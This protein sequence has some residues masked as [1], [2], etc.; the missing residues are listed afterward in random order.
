MTSQNSLIPLST[1]L[2]RSAVFA[3]A[4]GLLIM[5]QPSERSS[6]QGTSVDVP[7][8]TG[9]PP[10]EIPVPPPTRPAIDVKDEFERATVPPVPTFV[11]TPTQATV[12]LQLPEVTPADVLPNPTATPAAELQPQVDPAAVAAPGTEPQPMNLVA[13]VEVRPMPQINTSSDAHFVNEAGE[14]WVVQIAPGPSRRRDLVINGM[15]YQEVYESIP[16][17]Q[18]E[19]LANPS[20]RHDS[21]MEVLFG[22]LRPTT[23]VRNDSPERIRNTVPAITSPY[24]STPSDVYAYPQQFGLVPGTFPFIN[25]LLP[26]SRLSF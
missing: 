2:G 15:S 8:P 6:A 23:I 20:Y 16:Y 9:E 22:Q 12:N 13:P 21:T 26:G 14:E 1:R 5:A 17:R 11:P 4:C 19:Y 7:A 3:V 18:S 10:V 25:P 24:L